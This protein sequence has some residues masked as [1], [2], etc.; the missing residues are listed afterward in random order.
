MLQNSSLKSLTRLIPLSTISSYVPERTSVLLAL[1]NFTLYF[2]IAGVTNRNTV[3][4]TGP[5][6]TSKMGV[7]PVASNTI[8]TTGRVAYATG[9]MVSG[10]PPISRV[11]TQGKFIF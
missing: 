2:Y 9:Q 1:Y 5:S 11:T 10:A 4:S 3:P 8:I 7:T 6:A